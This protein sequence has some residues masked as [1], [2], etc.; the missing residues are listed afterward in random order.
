VHPATLPP[1]HAHGPAG[2]SPARLGPARGPLFL[3]QLPDP[4]RAAAKAEEAE[5][6]KVEPPNAPGFALRDHRIQQAI[7]YPVWYDNGP[8]PPL[9]AAAFGRSMQ[10]HLPAAD[11][12][13][14]GLH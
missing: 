8:L 9:D 10:P 3:R 7:R 13:A 5:S 14:D 4:E 1:F 11:F 6:L 12:H 2:R